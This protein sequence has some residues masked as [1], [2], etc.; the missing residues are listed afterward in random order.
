MKLLIVDDVVQEL[1]ALKNAI[2]WKRLGVNQVF[3]SY[4]VDSA[5]D[6]IKENQIDILICDIEMPEHTGIDLLQRIR[7]HK[8]PIE[9]ILLTEQGEYQYARMAVKLDAFDYLLKPIEFRTLEKELH[10]LIAKIKQERQEEEKK[11]YGNYWIE[12]QMLVKEL[13]WKNVCLERIV[14]QPEEIEKKAKSVN[15]SVDKDSHYKLVL[16]TIKNLEELYQKWGED[17]CHAAVQNLAQGIVKNNSDISQVIVIYT[18]VIIILNENEFDVF[19]EKCEML[20]S[21]CKEM[22][23][24]IILC[25]ISKPVYCEEF[26]DT[27][28]MLLKYSKDDVLGQNNIIEVDNPKHNTAKEEILLPTQ[29][30]EL[31]YAGHMKTLILKVRHFLTDLARNNN[32]NE[33]NFRIF[34]QDMLQMFFTFMEKK[35][36]KAHELYENHEI[37]KSYKTAILSIDGMC[38]WIQKCVDFIMQGTNRGTSTGKDRLVYLVQKYITSDLKTEITREMIGRILN[39]NPDYVNRVFKQETGMTIKEYTIHKRIQKAQELLTTTDLT[40]S[41]VAMS[42]G[43]DNFSYFIKLFKKQTQYTPKQ[44]KKSNKCY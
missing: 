8:Y 43:Y 14:N 4:N 2:E 32:L 44:Y 11:S 21:K 26:S 12:N 37:Y 30:S 15:V 25:Y 39:M 6:I 34:Q 41:E 1:R 16:I 24:A 31:L 10:T 5:W 36:L 13:F 18:R 9:T 19:T 33:M 29:W 40:I 28:R 17:L 38:L 42:V 27:Y 20:V 22:L 23:E 35:E 3:T 7:E